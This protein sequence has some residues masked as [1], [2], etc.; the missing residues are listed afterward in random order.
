MIED[1]IT[2]Y[3]VPS[4]EVISRSNAPHDELEATRNTI[5]ESK[6]SYNVQELGLQLT[7]TTVLRQICDKGNHDSIKPLG[8]VSSSFFG[9]Y[10]VLFLF[11]LNHVM[12]KMGTSLY[13]NAATSILALFSAA[14]AWD[15]LVLWGG[16]V[17]FRSINIDSPNTLKFKILKALSY[18][19]FIL[20]AILTPYLLKTSAE[21]GKM[22]GINFFD[23]NIVQISAMI[24]ASTIA[25]LSTH[26]VVKGGIKL[27]DSP[28]NCIKGEMTFFIHSIKSIFHVLPSLLVTFVNLFIGMSVRAKGYAEMGNWMIIGSS[29]I[30]SLFVPLFGSGVTKIT[31]NFSEIV[32][33]FSYIQAST[34]ASTLTGC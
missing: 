24:V 31:G 15:N 33:I 1:E 18:P 21:L 11:L 20:H 19:R 22:A 9:V 17:G 16:S 23:R 4:F 32:L 27:D 26:N 6:Q 7:S 34:I 14:F 30:L 3:P 28:T 2:A 10:G 5:T 13:T 12:T 25:C 29:A 8:I